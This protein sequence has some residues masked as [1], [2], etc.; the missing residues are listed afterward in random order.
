[1]LW[2]CGILRRYSART[3]PL[4]ML[5]PHIRYMQGRENPDSARGLPE[6]SPRR[7]GSELVARIFPPKGR[8]P[9]VRLVGVAVLVLALLGEIVLTLT[10]AYLIDLSVSLM[11]LWAELARKHLELTL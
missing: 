11:E 1:M 8:G 2:T 10:V 7:R 6:R 4:L 9:L 5:R 3:A